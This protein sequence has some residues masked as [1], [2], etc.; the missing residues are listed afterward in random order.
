MEYVQRVS[1]LL[2]VFCLGLAL[3]SYSHPYEICQRKYDNIENYIMEC[4]WLLENQPAL[5]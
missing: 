2:L 5:R 1:L 3:G 4:V